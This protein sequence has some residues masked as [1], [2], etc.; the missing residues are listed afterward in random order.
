MKAEIIG[1]PNDGAFAV[2][3]EHKQHGAPFRIGYSDYILS[4]KAGETPKLY[5]QKRTQA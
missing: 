5:F 1:G 4:R 2:V 3:P